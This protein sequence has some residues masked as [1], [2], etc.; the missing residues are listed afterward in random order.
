MPRRHFPVAG[1]VT[2]IVTM[3]EVEAI[4]IGWSGKK[5]LL[6]KTIYSGK[7]KIGKIDGIIVTPLS[8]VKA[9]LSLFAIIDLGSFLALAR[10]MQRYR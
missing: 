7:K 4:V 8:D 2:F 3:V 6:G 10:M 1:T 5:G 9:P